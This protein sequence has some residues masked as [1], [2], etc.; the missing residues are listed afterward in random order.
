MK[1]RFLN[2]EKK[3]QFI[4]FSPQPQRGGHIYK[5]KPAPPPEVRSTDYIYVA[6]QLIN[7]VGAPH[8]RGAAAVLLF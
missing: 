1:F 7:V 6:G 4:V 3:H 2:F 8:L 5:G